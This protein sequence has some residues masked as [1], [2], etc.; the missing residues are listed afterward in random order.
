ML[1]RSIKAQKIET[2]DIAVKDEPILQAE[3]KKFVDAKCVLD[4]FCFI[5]CTRSL[6]NYGGNI[7]TIIGNIL[8]AKECREHIALT[9]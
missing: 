1:F 6:I 8:L 3:A 2:K 5:A 9:E 7:F 4:V